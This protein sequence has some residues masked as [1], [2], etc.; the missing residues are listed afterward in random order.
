[1]RQSL[2]SINLVAWFCC[3]ILG[4]GFAPHHQIAGQ[5]PDPRYDR[6]LEDAIILPAGTRTIPTYTVLVIEMTTGLSSKYSRVGDRFRARIVSPVRNANGRNL[7]PIGTLVDG[8]V[9][10]VRP[11]KWPRKAG[12]MSI[13]FTRIRLPNGQPYSLRGTLTNV[14]GG[15]KLRYE[16]ELGIKP[17][18]TAA[19]DSI[20]I[21][22]GTGSG[23]IIGSIAGSALAGVGIG[24]AA[25]ATL[26]LL[27]PGRNVEIERG[28]RFGLEL[29]RSLYV[30]PRYYG[31][32]TIWR[33]PCPPCP[34][35]YPG[36]PR[37]PVYD[38]GIRFP[39]PENSV[40]TP[41]PGSGLI[42]LSDVRV[43]R[44]SDGTVYILLTAQ[45]PSTGWQVSTSNRVSGDTVEVGIYGTPPINGSVRQT[46]HPTPS[47]IVIPD[48]NGFIRRVI[49]QASNGPRTVAVPSSSLLPAS[50]YPT[51][52]GPSRPVLQPSPS[53]IPSSGPVG[54]PRPAPA[55]LVKR[56]ANQLERIRYDF[57]SSVGVWMN[58]DGSYDVSKSRKLT[59][60]ERLLLDRTGSLLKFVRDYESQ[61]DAST[62]NEIVERI[63]EDTQV[64]QQ[65][66]ARVRMSND[67]N[68]RFRSLFNDV[69]MLVG[70]IASPV[71]G[72][73]PVNSQPSEPLTGGPSS[74]RASEA[75]KHIQLVQYDFATSVQAW[76]NPDGSYDAVGTRRLTADET[77]ILD[78]L[79]AL[80]ASLRAFDSARDRRQNAAR[81][82]EE[83]QKVTQTWQRVRV[84]QDLNQ[85]FNRMSQSIQT[86]LSSV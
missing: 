33:G 49:V 35:G 48:R 54:T 63:R 59:D 64:I 75:L 70:S 22:G 57:G 81:I 30:G 31:P 72:L 80:N 16:E 42:D 52:P 24:A 34:P 74:A 26:A 28:D 50:G 19:R 84:S 41:L 23:A 39:L 66:W 60:D 61:S 51:T 78:G 85:K 53:R 11:A 14:R 20:I 68:Q 17:G 38:G 9:T 32:P 12:Y 37:G 47:P 56:I 40:S 73:V 86:L 7:I 82:Q 2:K 1:M 21:G 43:E 3:L 18:S 62:R 76:L 58:Q 13:L 45:T 79:R 69:Q 25:G 4:A 27:M 8:V 55:T 46:S 65:A 5:N 67:L 77:Q 29:L 15:E 10:D 36:P 44:S 71:P 6:D 83:L